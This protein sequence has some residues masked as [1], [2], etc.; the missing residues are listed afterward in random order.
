MPPMALEYT[1]VMLY[2]E[3]I[4]ETKDEQSYHHLTVDHCRYGQV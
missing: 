1:T 3:I 4:L 2:L